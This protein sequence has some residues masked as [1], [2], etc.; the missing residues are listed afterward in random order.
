MNEIDCAVNSGMLRAVTNFKPRSNIHTNSRYLTNCLSESTIICNVFKAFSSAYVVDYDCE[1]TKL[2]TQE[3]VIAHF[4][5]R[6]RLRKSASRDRNCVRAAGCVSSSDRMKEI[7][8]CDRRQWS[9][10]PPTAPNQF[11]SSMPC[12]YP[13]NGATYGFGVNIEYRKS[14]PLYR[15]VPIIMTVRQ[16]PLYPSS[17]R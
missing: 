10:T 12:N 7:T 16:L 5:L 11:H 4:V 13:A 1:I 15:T 6:R 14:E 9:P 17:F 8:M 2:Y 3:Y